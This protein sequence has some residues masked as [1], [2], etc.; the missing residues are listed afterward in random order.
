MTAPLV[1]KGLPRLRRHNP[2]HQLAWE[3][4][5]SDMTEVDPEIP[6]HYIE[7]SRQCSRIDK[8]YISS[9]PWLLLQ[10][11]ARADVPLA[12]EDLY[13]RGISDHAPVHLRFAHRQQEDDGLRQ[14]IPKYIFE[15]PLFGQHLD[16]L[17][18]A[19][20]WQSYVPFT[21]LRELKRLQREAARL[22][23]DD[24]TNSRAPCTAAALTTCRSISRAVW[25]NDEK[26]AR[27][28]AARTEL[29]ASFLDLSS[30][31]QVSLKA[32]LEFSRKFES[33]QQQYQDE[34]LEALHSQEMA[35]GTPA[36]ERLRLRR[37]QRAITR[38][39]KLWAPSGKVLKLKAIEIVSMEYS[40]I[41]ALVR[42]AK[43]TI[44]NW[45]LW[46][47]RLRIVVQNELEFQHFGNL[48]NLA[49]RHWK[50]P[51]F[52]WHLREAATGFK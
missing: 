49:P 33:L 3:S 18:A 45:D 26:A 37:L 20:P 13:D 36:H 51:P 6:T 23:R 8:I 16:T 41:S 27:T 28:L 19:S 31:P 17:L 46:L 22:T 48:N 50:E 5:L 52:A 35:A 32:P 47:R 15:H 9:P 44:R 10:W 34:R 24:L 30:L 1:N 14:S 43:E 29:G 38:R 7:Q 25:R 11:C 42:S 2:E 21:Q 4:V 12:P 39:G 40:T